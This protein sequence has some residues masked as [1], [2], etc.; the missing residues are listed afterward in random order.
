MKLNPEDFASQLT[1]VDEP[2]FKAIH[3]D[4]LVTLS[5]NNSA[6]K[7]QLAPNIVA[8]TTRFNRTSFLV[9]EEILKSNNPDGVSKKTSIDNEAKWRSEV[10]TQFIKIA[11]LL[12]NEH[13]NLHSCYAIISA[14]NSSPIY[15]LSRSW[16]FVNQKHM[17]S[18][19]KMKR[20]FR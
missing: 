11:R 9:V 19:E 15:R 4:E 6:K 1:L 13:N 3:R 7:Q 8:F 16:S 14:L 12:L 17:N 20:L 18:Y 10:I 2:L 5:W